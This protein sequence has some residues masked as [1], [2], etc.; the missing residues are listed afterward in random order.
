MSSYMFLQNES[1]V[2]SH[3]SYWSTS[4][5]SVMIMAGRQLINIRYFPISW[6]DKCLWYKRLWETVTV[7]YIQEHVTQWSI[8]MEE[9]ILALLQCSPVNS[10]QRIS[11]WCGES[12]SWVW[13][14]IHDESLYPYHFLP[15][16]VLQ[17]DDYDLNVQFCQWTVM[18]CQNFC[19]ILFN[20]EA[21]FNQDGNNSTQ[22]SHL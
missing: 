15:V 17:L 2:H 14:S 11:N 5:H 21:Q 12:A 13:Q 8:T 19:H 16:Q 4:M 7:L 9:H 3:W 20:Y 1:T 18:C 6:T 10:S 22:N